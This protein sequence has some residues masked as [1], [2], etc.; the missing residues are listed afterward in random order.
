[1]PDGTTVR[2]FAEGGRESKDFDC[3]TL[4]VGAKLQQTL[5]DCFARRTAPGGGLRTM[6]SIEQAFRGVRLFAR[7]LSTLPVPP[8]VIDDVGPEHI[9][10]YLEFRRS[11]SAATKFDEEIRL[12]KSSLREYEWHSPAMVAKLRE[13]NP[14]RVR[15]SGRSS[16][17]RAEFQR[18]ATAARRDLRAAASRIRRNRELLA[19]YRAGTSLDPD[20]RMELLDYVERYGDVPRKGENARRPGDVASWVQQG[21]F[22]AVAKI[23]CMA[24]LSTAEISA[25][26]VLLA[27]LTGQNASVI[28]SCPAAHHRAD[29]YAGGVETAILD[30]N[31]PRRRQRAFMNLALSAVPDWISV[32]GDLAEVSARDELHTAFGVYSLLFEL[33]TSSRRIAGSDLLLIAYCSTG[34]S[35]RGFRPHGGK[36]GWTT[37]WAQRHSL[38]ADPVNDKIALPLEVG[39]AR[40]RLTFLELHQK[41]VAHSEQTLVSDYLG[42]NR[43]N[44]GA[45]RKVVADALKEEVAKANAIPVLQ[46]LSDDEIAAASEDP[47]ELAATLA[48]PQS[49]V[50]RMLQGKL[51]TVMNAC[52][53]N[54]HGPNTPQGQPCRASF[55]LCLSCPCARALPRHIPVQLLVLDRLTKRRSEMTPLAWTKRFALPHAQLEN[56]LSRHDA[57]TITRARA[58]ITTEQ[59]QIV[60][61]FLNRELDVR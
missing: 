37:P 15:G 60:D 8:Y 28:I 23:V 50:R 51:D 1:M 57:D 16:Y 42:R 10:G 26:A 41:P 46:M 44:L 21:G 13:P 29:G 14:P 47:T 17:S 27:I 4:P 40:I 25:G 31:K 53:D 7:F 38:L 11:E 59:Q 35:S 39:L 32:P 20:R 6:A 3:S 49:V 43:G 36:G 30:T 33:T 61:R 22:G 19:R 52:I 45:Y 2:C 55:M 34:A 9:D 24:H 54:L 48:L 5:A 12:V 58:S 18:I 56:L